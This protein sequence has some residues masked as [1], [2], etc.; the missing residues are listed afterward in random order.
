MLFDLFIDPVAVRAGYWVWFV[1]GT[2]YYDIPMLNYVG[3]F[4]LMSLAPFGWILIARRR[5]WGY[6]R[7]GLISIGALVPLSIAAVGF[8]LLLNGAVAALGLQ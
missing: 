3:W 4:V 6:W 5:D 2:V 1:K 7:K 8:S